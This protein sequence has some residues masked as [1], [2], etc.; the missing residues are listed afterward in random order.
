M[1]KNP[2]SGRV[3]EKAGMTFKGILRHSIFRWGS[4]EDS[5]M[6]SILRAEYVGG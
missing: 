3:M 6:Y 4:F 5:A 2:A 1:T